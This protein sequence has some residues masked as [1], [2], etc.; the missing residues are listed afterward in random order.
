MNPV[1]MG[2]GLRM[3]QFEIVDISASVCQESF[4][5]G[6]F[7]LF[8]YIYYYYY[9][10]VMI[11][12]IYRNTL[13]CFSHQGS[14]VLTWCFLLSKFSNIFSY[15]PLFRVVKSPLVV[16]QAYS[17]STIIQHTEPILGELLR[18]WQG[19]SHAEISCK[20]QQLLCNCKGST[21]KTFGY[22]GKNYWI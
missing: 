1:I 19:F 22:S 18:L 13:S 2:K 5:I 17:T 20:T 15:Y 12:F 7:S 16:F 21:S 3:P 11:H 9:L 14:H 10:H 6:E 8:C 4:Q